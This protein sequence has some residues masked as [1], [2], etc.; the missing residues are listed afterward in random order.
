MEGS[1]RMKQACRHLDLRAPA[2]GSLCGQRLHVAD[3]WPLGSQSCLCTTV[4]PTSMVPGT[5]HSAL[6]AEPSQGQPGLFETANVTVTVT[7]LVLFARTFQGTEDLGLSKAP[8]PEALRNR[9]RLCWTQTKAPACLPGRQSPPA[10]SLLG[11]VTLLSA[12]AWGPGTGAMLTAG[13]P[14]ADRHQERGTVSELTSAV[15]LGP[16]RAQGDRE[17]RHSPAHRTGTLSWTCLL[18]CLLFAATVFEK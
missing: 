4:T 6:S 14:Q 12:L 9:P 8:G 15:W 3:V 16:H 13:H 7:S 17:R 18:E 1:L 5:L 11:P 10:A 2:Q